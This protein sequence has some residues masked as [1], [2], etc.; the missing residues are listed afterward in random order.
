MNKRAFQATSWGDV[1]ICGSG[2]VDALYV[3]R[4]EG[5]ADQTPA[6]RTD[7]RYFS[8][9]NL[10]CAH[11]RLSTACCSILVRLPLRMSL[12]DLESSSDEDGDYATTNVTLGYASK[13][14]TGD[15][16]SQLGGYHVCLWQCPRASILTSVDVD[17]L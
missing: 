1:G 17:R 4:T 11:T 9:V 7:H 13:E 15:D 14:S 6:A 10:S 12:N 2:A 8:E 5:P 16:V 3:S